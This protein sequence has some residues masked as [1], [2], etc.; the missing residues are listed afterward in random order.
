MVA[1]RLASGTIG[2]DEVNYARRLAE[3][4]EDRTGDY[5]LVEPFSGAERGRAASL[6][7]QL[8]STEYRAV[9]LKSAYDEYDSSLAIGVLYG[10]ASSGSDPDGAAL[11]AI[12]NIARKA[13]TG[14]TAVIRAACDAL[15]AIIRY[16]AGDIALEGTKQLS[17][18]LQDP[19][20][21]PVR[22]YARM[23]LSK[24]LR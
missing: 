3:I 4:L 12:G 18:F 1:R 16:S 10:I 24:I 17:R 20:D 6:L 15:Y 14:E 23:T 11:A 9:L 22:I 21:D 8:G 2:S 13:G 19:Y 7:G 5:P